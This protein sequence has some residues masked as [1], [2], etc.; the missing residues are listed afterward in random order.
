MS[1]NWQILRFFPRWFGAFPLVSS[2]WEMVFNKQPEISCILHPISI[3]AT[4][5]LERFG[6]I[7]MTALIPVE[8]E[9][10]TVIVVGLVRRGFLSLRQ[11]IGIVMGQISVQPWRPLY[12]WFQA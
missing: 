4:P 12:D 11:A 10:F 2:T 7:V 6:G 3:P 8:F 1:V 9:E 5:F